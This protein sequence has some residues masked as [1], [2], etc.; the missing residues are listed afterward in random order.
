MGED[1]TVCVC[2]CDLHSHSS[3]LI[4]TV[5]S[6]CLACLYTFSK[7]ILWRRK[8]QPTSVFLPGKFHEERS[9]VGYSP[10]GC[11]ELDRTEHTIIILKTTLFTRVLDFIPEDQQEGNKIKVYSY[12]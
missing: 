12:F 1:N 6:Q 10:W 3:S 4:A 8:W 9:L 2:V 11:K 7:E 5:S